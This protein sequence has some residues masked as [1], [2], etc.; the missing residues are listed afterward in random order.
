[1]KKLT[2]VL[3]CCMVLVGCE[4][5]SQSTYESTM[6]VTD[7]AK[8]KETEKEIEQSPR[9][10]YDTDE[11]VVKTLGEVQFQIP[12]DWEKDVK[13]NGEFTY[14]YDDK[15]MFSTQHSEIDFTNNEL[16][17]GAEGYV[18]GLK[19]GFDQ[20]EEERINM[21]DVS[22]TEAIEF[23]AKVTVGK[24]NM[25]IKILTFCH[26]GNIYVFA[27][28]VD[29]GSKKDYIAEYE[30]FKESI[31]IQDN[32]AE[33][34]KESD[35]IN[36]LFE[37]FKQN[38]IDSA[39]N[40]GSTDIEKQMYY[41]NL[42]ASLPYVRVLTKE[43]WNNSDE[44]NKFLLAIG[45]FYTHYDT[46]T[47][48]HEIGEQGFLIAEALMAQGNVDIEEAV[49]HIE[50]LLSK[51]ENDLSL[52]ITNSEEIVEHVDKNSE[53]TEP[54]QLIT[55][56]YVVGED[57]PAGK[58]DIVGIEE[59]SVY[60]NSPGKSYGDIVSERI[61]PGETIYAN[62]RLEDGC[63]VEVVLGGKIQLQLK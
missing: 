22:E 6:Q 62:V 14:Y 8:A 47:K 19:S 57:I 26:S 27:F 34:I 45:Y 7:G 12:S 35:G 36:E 18:N 50:E 42:I 53:N 48:G 51:S 4:N 1:M 17:E 31:L 49:L 29:A 38:I 20:C 63:T 44:F 58:Y 56:M 55:G 5:K 25:D 30:S 60:V 59:G 41:D 21:I 3:M 11:L 13:E 39:K 15:L 28:Y 46:G 23:L 61:K 32:N 54:I 2:M 37:G 9:N 43:T 10:L 40:L 16:I 33:I 52:S 24:K